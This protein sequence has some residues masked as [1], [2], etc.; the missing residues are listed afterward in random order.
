MVRPGR[1][2]DEDSG[3][4]AGDGESSV[5]GETSGTESS[6]SSSHDAD[7]ED[8]AMSSEG[9]DMSVWEDHI[10]KHGARHQ[11]PRC[12]FNRNKKSGN[13]CASSRPARAAWL[14]GWRNAAACAEEVGPSGAERVAWPAFATFGGGPESREERSGHGI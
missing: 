1:E 11:C 3:S 8:A 10:R 9:S 14:H 2:E 7:A 13:A 4:E 12:V 5:S 6:A